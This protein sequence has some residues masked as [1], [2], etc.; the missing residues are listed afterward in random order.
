MLLRKYQVWRLKEVGKTGNCFL[1]N[2]ATL[3]GLIQGA[4]SVVIPLDL[5]FMLFGE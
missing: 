1:A 2:K 4:K 3:N 5:N